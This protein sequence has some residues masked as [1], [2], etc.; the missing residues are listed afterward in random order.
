[1]AECNIDYIR[2]VQIIV[3]CYIFVFFSVYAALQFVHNNVIIQD[4]VKSTENHFGQES[5]IYG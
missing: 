4:K 2:Y 5:V 1:M 3:Q